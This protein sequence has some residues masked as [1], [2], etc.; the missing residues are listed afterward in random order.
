MNDSV[1]DV[2]PEDIRRCVR[3]YMRRMGIGD[4]NILELRMR[5]NKP[6]YMTCIAG[7]NEVAGCSFMESGSSAAEMVSG[8]RCNCIVTR[9]DIDEV[10]D[11]I[12]DYS[13]YAFE[14]EI[15]QGFITIR[16]GHRVG[17]AGQTVLKS[18]KITNL[19]NI[20]F[21][22]IRF[23]HQKKGC[24]EKLI[25]YIA[26]GNGIRNTLIISPPG[27]GKTTL[28]RDVIRLISTGSDDRN[29]AIVDER[30]EIAG[31]YLGEPQLNVGI[32]TDVLDACP[33][34]EGMM[35]LIRS[36]NPDVIAVDEIGSREDIDAIHYVSNCGCSI[37]ATVHGSS[38]DDIR[39]RPVLRRLVE[40][41]RFERYIV[42]SR[43]NG[44]GT[45][46][47]IFDE[48]GN[49]VDGFSFSPDRE[50]DGDDRLSGFGNK[51]G[52]EYAKA[53]IRTS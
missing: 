20:S 50:S 23:A 52:Y 31:C 15:C 28:L 21:I 36:M 38:V 29:V 27:C 30:S 35:M 6:V 44:V 32:R 17:M 7:G 40:E 2:L 14:N 41:R 4:E 1:F 43:R 37:L 13:P 19:K 47:S 3:T 51:A 10:I 48:R 12:T 33:K 53:N 8:H 18:G 45:V 25:P 24:G 26:G 34:V 16:G 46:E 39:T 11:R 42:L 5:I 9:R 22:N 49:P